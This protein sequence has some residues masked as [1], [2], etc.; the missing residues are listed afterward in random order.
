MIIFCPC[1]PYNRNRVDV[2]IKIDT[3]T[4]S[5]YLPI[6]ISFSL[7]PCTVSE[8]GKAGKILLCSITPVKKSERVGKVVAKVYPL[9]IESL[10]TA[11]IF[12]IDS[13]F[14][15]PVFIF[16]LFLGNIARCIPVRTMKPRRPIYL[17]CRKKTLLKNFLLA[18][19]NFPDS[20]RSCRTEMPNC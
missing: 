1:N 16:E 9:S 14:F 4:C 10:V 7:T 3:A 20:R 18:I 8:F 19:W 15:C 13:L 11:I 6:V 5:I 17:R 12:G 2:C